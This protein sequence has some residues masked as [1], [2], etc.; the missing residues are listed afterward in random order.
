[1]STIVRRNWLQSVCPHLWAASVEKPVFDVGD[2]GKVVGVRI[3]KTCRLCG[4]LYISR[5]H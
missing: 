1:M 3:H 2:P 5:L 4:A